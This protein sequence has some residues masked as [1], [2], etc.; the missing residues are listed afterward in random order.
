LTT[1][2][3]DDFH[4]TRVFSGNEMIP[5]NT[6]EGIGKMVEHEDGT[7]GRQRKRW[8]WPKETG[9]KIFHIVKTYTRAAHYPTRI[10]RTTGSKPSRSSTRPEKWTLDI[11]MTGRFK[12][13]KDRFFGRKNTN[14]IEYVLSWL[15]LGYFRN[16]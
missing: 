15:L 4:S 14:R 13:P 11:K 12:R 10:L 3:V 9:D 1:L 8:A 6:I 5:W 7:W 16:L 2:L